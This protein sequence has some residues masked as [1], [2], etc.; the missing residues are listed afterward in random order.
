MKTTSIPHEIGS[1]RD[2]VTVGPALNSKPRTR[3][4]PD[5]T[6]HPSRVRTKGKVRD[7]V[8]RVPTDTSISRVPTNNEPLLSKEE[9]AVHCQV[10][11]RPSMPRLSAARLV[12]ED[13]GRECGFT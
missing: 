3:N 6:P 13:R 2:A 10:C 1:G 12:F 11:L 8:E 4:Q 7:A 9:V 5:G